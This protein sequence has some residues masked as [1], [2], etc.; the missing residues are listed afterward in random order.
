MYTYECVIVE[1]KDL[2]NDGKL[3]ERPHQINIG[4]RFHVDR[5]SGTVLGAGFM[6]P[7]P[8]AKASVVNPGLKGESFRVLYIED[9]GPSGKAVEFLQI[10]EYISGRIK[11]FQAVGWK[12]ILSG[13]CE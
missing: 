11:P 1:E 3:V 9:K 4:R 6:T 2:S 12:S 13:T 8:R 7:L 10:E 5:E